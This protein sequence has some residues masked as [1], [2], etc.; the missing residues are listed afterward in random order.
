M[1]ALLHHCGALVPFKDWQ[2][3]SSPEASKLPEIVSTKCIAPAGYEYSGSVQQA[4][5]AKAT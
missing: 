3:A 4:T 5:I 2:Q 1:E